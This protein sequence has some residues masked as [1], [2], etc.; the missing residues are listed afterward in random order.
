MERPELGKD[1]ES[2]GGGLSVGLVIGVLVGAA[3]ALFV[4][5]N[6]ERT[7]VTWL[8]FEAEQPL[9][10]VLLVTAAASLVVT[11]LIGG[12]RRRRKRKQG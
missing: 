11:E 1:G 4:V 6:T 9:W 2:A 12:A 5:Q 10:V 8:F 3:L 7:E